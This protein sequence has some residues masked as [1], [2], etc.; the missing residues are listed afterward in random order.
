MNENAEN[1]TNDL[2]L[3]RSIKTS[4]D[5]NILKS[6]I[7]KNVK[8][9]SDI[10]KISDSIQ[11]LLDPLSVIIKLAIISQKETGVKISISNNI[12]YI[13]E[14]GIFQSV[15]RY[16]FNSNKSDLHLLYN[17]IELACRHFL[18]PTNDMCTTIK[19][20]F[21]CALNGLEKLKQTYQD[22]PLIVICLN[23]YSYL[24]KNYLGENINE[25]LF[26]KDE[27]SSYYTDDI[28]YK[29][30]NYWTP[31]KIKLVLE[32]SEYLYNNDRTVDSIQCL[33]VLMKGVDLNTQKLLL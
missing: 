21:S 18:D 29:L 7:G 8:S 3:S 25:T 6:I 19:N 27:M 24:I 22:H 9:N 13:Q 31:D 2:D 10:G 14:H 4:S 32:M 15:V 11:Y 17:P 28:I 23:Y 12:L 16:Y 5:V 26:N 20:L 33:E 1:S 30:N